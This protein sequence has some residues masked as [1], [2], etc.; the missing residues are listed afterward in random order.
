MGVVGGGILGV[1]IAREVVRRL[2]ACGF[3]ARP[4][5]DGVYATRR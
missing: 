3:H 4:E 1:A 2:Q 5:L